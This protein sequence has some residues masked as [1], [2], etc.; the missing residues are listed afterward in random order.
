MSMDSPPDQRQTLQFAAVTVD[1]TRT[2][3]DE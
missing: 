1:C 3:S 2:Q